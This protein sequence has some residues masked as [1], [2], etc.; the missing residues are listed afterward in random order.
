MPYTRAPNQ[1][2]ITIEGNEPCDKAHL[3]SAINLD[4]M[5]G[6]MKDFSG[7]NAN[8]FILWCY[9]AKNRPGYSFALSSVDV[10][11]QTGLKRDAYDNAVA[12]LIGSGYLVPTPAKG[13]N[14]YDFHE[15]PPAQ[16][17]PLGHVSKGSSLQPV[18]K[19]GSG[20]YKEIDF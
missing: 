5:E 13:R 11:N 8:A 9:F 3:Y 12:L 7:R 17:Q 4:A 2:Q 19:R 18:L 14:T 6:A 15:I 1:K 10:F 16:K 20:L